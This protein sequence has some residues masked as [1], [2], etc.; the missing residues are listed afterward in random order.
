MNKKLRDKLDNNPTLPALPTTPSEKT[1]TVDNHLQSLQMLHWLTGLLVRSE[2]KPQLLKECAK[3]NKPVLL[4]GV[5]MIDE[6]AFQNA[7]P[8][9]I[10][11]IE[12]MSED[13]EIVDALNKIIN[14]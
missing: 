6:K 13:P 2:S 12:R 10:R 5:A 7:R 1:P 4:M 11:M 14:A 3:L 9:L 8:Y